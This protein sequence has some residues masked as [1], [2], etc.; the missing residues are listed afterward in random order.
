M[1]RDELIALLGGSDGLPIQLADGIFGLLL[2]TGNSEAGVDVPGE[3]QFRWIAYERIVHLGEGAF[4][5]LP[6]GGGKGGALHAAYRAGL[7]RAAEIGDAEV[8]KMYGPALYQEGAA[9]VVAAIRKAA[10]EAE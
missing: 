10:Q 8:R 2:R 3:E 6:M 7:E 9:A 5:E 1:T 4:V